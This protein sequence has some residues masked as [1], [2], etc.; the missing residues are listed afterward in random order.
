MERRDVCGVFEGQRILTS[1][2]PWQRNDRI[3]LCRHS[4]VQQG[5]PSKSA[6]LGMKEG[7]L[8]RLLTS[9]TSRLRTCTIPE[10]RV[11]SR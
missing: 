1:A 6:K 7:K 5:L 10:L 11:G 2:N 9:D 4:R 3:R 8:Y